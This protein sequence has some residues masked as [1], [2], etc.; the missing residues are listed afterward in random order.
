VAF[1]AHWRRRCASSAAAGGAGADPSLLLALASMFKGELLAGG[2]LQLA[3]TLLKFSTPV[4][5]G[6]GR[7]VALCCR[8]STLYQIH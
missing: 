5:R 7:I 4:M 1:E 3:T 6:L 2:F 8:S